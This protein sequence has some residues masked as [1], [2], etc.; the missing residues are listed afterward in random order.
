MSSPPG[1]SEPGQRPEFEEYS[2]VLSGMRVI[3]HEGGT[4]EVAAG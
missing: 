2:I 3:E 4:L 1:W